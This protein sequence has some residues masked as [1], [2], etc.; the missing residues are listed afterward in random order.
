M[1]VSLAKRLILSVSMHGG[2]YFFIQ[3]FSFF[4]FFIPD[5]RERGGTG[6]VS[7]AWAGEL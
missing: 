2:H 6:W 5:G 3:P 1:E 7:A 4:P